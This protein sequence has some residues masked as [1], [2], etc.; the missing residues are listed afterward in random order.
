MDD[1][2]RV[3]LKERKLESLYISA[4][5]SNKIQ[6]QNVQQRNDAKE[7]QR[8]VARTY[9]SILE[10]NKINGMKT[11]RLNVWSAARTPNSFN[12]NAQQALNPFMNLKRMI[13]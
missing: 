7:R 4:D 11:D 3:P 5:G 9:N 10:G 8:A 12:V 2:K 13:T 1:I 6:N